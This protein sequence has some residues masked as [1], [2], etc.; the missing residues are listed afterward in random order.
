MM[1]ATDTADE[2]GSATARRSP[3]PERRCLVT[4]SVRPKESLVRFVV[5]PDGLVTPDL[6]E[7]LPGRGMWV[8]ADR[9]ALE[10]AVDARRFGRAARRG[11]TIPDGLVDRVESM[12]ARR[13]TELLGLARRAGLAVAGY[14][15]VRARLRAGDAALLLAAVDGAADGRGK[16]R[17]LAPELPVAD[18]MTA[19]EI[20]AAFAREHVVHAA[21]AAGGLTE[22]L[23]GEL[24]R[25]AG[26]RGT[27]TATT[28]GDGTRAAAGR[29]TTRQ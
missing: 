5:D 15:K 28:V 23:R 10:Q 27:G 1:M 16:L 26:V 8:S 25:L 9:G 13:C 18:A 2:I 22:R 21:L 14:E 12:L 19:A 20:G 6:E 4:R 29:S 24:A 17:A 3:G 7:R 11:V